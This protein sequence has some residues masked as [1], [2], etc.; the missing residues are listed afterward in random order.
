MAADETKRH[1][2]LLL[3]AKVPEHS[4]VVNKTVREAG[5]KGMERLFL[6]AVERQVLDQVQLSI[7][8]RA[9]KRKRPVAD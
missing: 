4:T 7:R 5:L 9:F 8:F 1:S 2:D 3:V 6:V